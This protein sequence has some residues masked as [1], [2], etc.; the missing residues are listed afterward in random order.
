MSA[1]RMETARDHWSV[2]LTTSVGCRAMDKVVV[3]TQK[4]LDFAK[5]GRALVTLT[6]SVMAHL[7]VVKMPACMTD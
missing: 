5:M 4:C 6:M 1:V 7:C 3:A 2:V